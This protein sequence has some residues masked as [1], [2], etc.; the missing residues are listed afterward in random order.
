[1]YIIEWKND[2]FHYPS[3]L[4]C[5]KF[6]IFGKVSEHQLIVV[7]FYFLI[8]EKNSSVFSFQYEFI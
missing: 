7:I 6:S 4:E 1:M 5:G 2:K 8:F 3:V